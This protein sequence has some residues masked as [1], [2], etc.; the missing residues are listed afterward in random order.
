MDSTPVS[1]G[2]RFE[3]SSA[4]TSPGIQIS[5]RDVTALYRQI[6]CL[7]YN[8]GLPR[9]TLLEL[10]DRIVTEFTDCWSR[11]DVVGIATRYGPDGPDI[12]SPS[13]G[14]FPHRSRPAL[15]ST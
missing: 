4:Q 5:S 13:G 1:V 8:Q 7:Q 11:D 12:E 6:D 15:R 10:S 9:S 14:D 3:L 2:K